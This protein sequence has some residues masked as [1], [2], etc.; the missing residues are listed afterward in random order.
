MWF[1]VKM[2]FKVMIQC[3]LTTNLSVMPAEPQ[4]ELEH[5]VV[6]WYNEG[7]GCHGNH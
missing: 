7:M 2:P 3:Y 1:F 4:S 5:T 6:L